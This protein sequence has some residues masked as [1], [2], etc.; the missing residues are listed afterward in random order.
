[1]SLPR[2]GATVVIENRPGGGTVLLVANSFVV[3]PALKPQNYDMSK[4]FD[5]VCYLAATVNAAL[6]KFGTTLEARK[7]CGRLVAKTVEIAA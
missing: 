6:V 5:P 4:S 2:P 7:L 1:M 3:N